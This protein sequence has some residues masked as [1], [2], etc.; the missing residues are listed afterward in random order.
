MSAPVTPDPWTALRRH[1]PARIALG[2][3]GSSLPTSEVLGFALA[4]A[5]ARDAVHAPFA[6]EATAAAIEALGPQ[7]V[8]VDSAAPDRATYL[9]RP[10]LGRTLSDAGRAAL[11]ARTRGACDL[12]IVIADGLSS[13]AVH[14]HAAPLVEALLPA[15]EEAG[16]R[17]A[18][19]VVARQA[20][21]ALG[22]V[23]GELLG[24]RLV[25]LLVGERPGLSSPD[26][27]GAYITFAPKVGRSDAERNCVSNIRAEGLSYPAA[28]FKLAWHAREA[29]RLGL[30]GVALKDESD[31]AARLEP[32]NRPVGL[33]PS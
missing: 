31:T 25:I 10:D 1:T 24:A 15:V 12:A 7:T 23:V 18:P 29:L 19:V 17:L 30:T 27:L 32:M 3:T 11:V 9:R 26:S 5:Q 14:A 28:A 21:V 16:W 22:D 33:S 13:T 6:A 8:I 2:R 4:H 20:R